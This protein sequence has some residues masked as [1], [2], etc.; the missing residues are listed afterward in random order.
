MVTPSFFPPLG[1]EGD[2]EA[3]GGRSEDVFGD[4]DAGAK[5]VDVS[6]RLT[7]AGAELELQRRR[8][9]VLSRDRRKAYL[10]G[11]RGWGECGGNEG[12]GWG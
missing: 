11:T 10:G 2:D 3:A 7:R 4:E 8:N 12:G 9:R 6:L 5:A 1:D